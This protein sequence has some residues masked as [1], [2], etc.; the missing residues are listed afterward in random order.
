M[1]TRPLVL[2]FDTS[3]PYVGA[4]LFQGDDVVAAVYDDMNRGQAEALMPALEALLSEI[5]ATW[6]DLDGI[7]VGVG[8]GNFTGIRL[9][10]A[11]ARGLA[12]SLDKPA[13]GVSLLDALAFGT[14]G[15]VLACLAAPRARVYVQSHARSPEIP[16]QLIALADLPDAWHQPGLACIGTAGAEIAQRLGGRHLPAA[17]APGSA[18]ARIAARDLHLPHPRPA[19]LYLRE[20]DAAPSRDAPPVILDDA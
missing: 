14:D 7:G 18:I 3:G 12:L 5:G 11:T 20:A 4:A 6:R 10:V 19:P 17:Y 13:I 16:A 9:S 8:P 15:P 2:G 1:T